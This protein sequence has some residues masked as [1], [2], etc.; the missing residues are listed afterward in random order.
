MADLVVKITED[1]TIENQQYGSTKRFVLSNINEV[2]KRVVSCVNG[3][4]TTVA[5]F[6]TETRTAAGAIKIGDAK[7]VRITNLH[8]SE[9]IELAIVGAATLYQITL[10]AGQSHVLGAADD[11]LLA[12]A[13]TSPSFGT[14]TDLKSIQIQPT[15]SSTVD[16]EVFVASS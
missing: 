2:F 11:L 6:E 13:D 7:Y 8:S 14:M 9:S 10:V 5:V 15:G 1:L 4:S 3:H 16:V 12:E